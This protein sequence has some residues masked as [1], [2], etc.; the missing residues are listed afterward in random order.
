MVNRILDPC[1]NL[2]L[3]LAAVAK[4]IILQHLPNCPSFILLW[5]AAARLGAV[6][7]PTNVLASADELTWLL[8][9]SN[10]KIAFTTAAHLPMLR[11]SQ[12]RLQ[13]LPSR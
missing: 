5:L 4:E 11:R 1:L 6:M 12:R 2:S 13:G 10:S 3:H 9:H 8:E 7:M